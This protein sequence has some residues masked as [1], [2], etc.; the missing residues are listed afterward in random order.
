MEQRTIKP[1]DNISGSE[2]HQEMSD[3][4]EKRDDDADQEFRVKDIVPSYD[5]GRHTRNLDKHTG[6]TGQEHREQN[7]VEK[8]IVPQTVRE[9]TMEKSRG[10]RDD[11]EVR[12]GHVQSGQQARSERLQFGKLGCIE[13]SAFLDDPFEHRPTVHRC[14]RKKRDDTQE[15]P[16]SVF[17]GP[18]RDTGRAAKRIRVHDAP[19]CRDRQKGGKQIEWQVFPVDRVHRYHFTRD[20]YGI[21]RAPYKVILPACAC[22]ICYEIFHLSFQQFSLRSRLEKH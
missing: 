17:H 21:Q 10:N 3:K 16:E 6:K 11:A 9:G 19:H 22:R 14:Q 5:C 2:L 7:G 20:R 8:H 18:A 13:K 4:G 12:M 1:F 15:F